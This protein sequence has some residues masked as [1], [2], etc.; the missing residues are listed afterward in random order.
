MEIEKPKLVYVSDE[1]P[2]FTR[3]KWGRGFIYKNE[4]GVKIS[5][6]VIIQ[7]IKD[8]VIPPIWQEVWICPDETG[9]LQST[10]KDMKSRKQ[11]IYHTE[12]VAYNQQTKF[13]R[14]KKFGSTLPIIRAQVEK[15]LRDK[16]WSRKKVCALVVHLLDEHYLRIGNQYYTDRNK[17]YGLTTLR[18]KHLDATKSSIT[19]NYKAKSNKHREI[20]IEDQRL[21]SLIKEISDLPGYEVF[22]YKDESTKW[23]SIDSSDVNE[24][25]N[26][27]SGKPFTAKDFRTWAGTKLAIEYYDKAKEEVSQNKRLTLEPT[28]IKKVA[29]S[30][31]NTV[32]TCRK[33]YI[34]PAVL[35]AVVS[36]GVNT[37]ASYTDE[38]LE[39]SEQLILDLI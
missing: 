9:H 2:G 14:L 37:T 30:L 29:K 16:D 28:L 10:G 18:R 5:D 7:R 27:I 6:Q 3:H 23:T 11:Y 35:E 34:H 26:N 4:D 36:N 21:V 31:G 20:K 39:D 22:R 12:W 25:I 1:D 38:H 24:Y 33:Y 17:T 19:F 32:A 8:L 13:A 15:D